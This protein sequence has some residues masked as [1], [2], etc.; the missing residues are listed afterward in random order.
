MLMETVMKNK[1]K[2]ISYIDLFAGAGGLSEGF[3]SVGLEPIAHVEMSAGSCK[4]LKTRACYYYLKE[5]N[6]L[7]RYYDHIEG[8][9]TTDLSASDI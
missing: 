4:A 9:I 6:N 7:V 3:S 1:S 2:K 8:N 5:Q